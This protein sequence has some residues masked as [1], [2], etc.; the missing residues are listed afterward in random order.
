[1]DIYL[2]GGI[3]TW[4]AELGFISFGRKGHPWEEM[5]TGKGCAVRFPYQKW[6]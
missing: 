6:F 5:D 4:D 1:M 3:C 2:K